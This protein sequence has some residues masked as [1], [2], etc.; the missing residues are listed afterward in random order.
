M[1][2]TLSVE[3]RIIRL[4]PPQI[5]FTTETAL[6]LELWFVGGGGGGGGACMKSLGQRPGII[7][8][9]GHGN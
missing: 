6:H 9:A 3:N 2:V 4:I 8:E 7:V 1:T 5:M